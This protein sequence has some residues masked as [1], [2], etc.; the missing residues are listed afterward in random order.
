MVAVSFKTRVALVSEV[1]KKKAPL[2][3]ISLSLSLQAGCVCIVGTSHLLRFLANVLP[4]FTVFFVVMP[5]NHAAG[6]V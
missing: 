4:T 1:S 6:R 3:A 2:Y 5:K